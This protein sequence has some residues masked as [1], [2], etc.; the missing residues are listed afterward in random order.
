[1]LL[2]SRCIYALSVLTLGCGWAAR[3]QV[4]VPQR[5]PVAAVGVPSGVGATAVSAVGGVQ[6]R[7]VNTGVLLLLNQIAQGQMTLDEAWNK[8]LLDAPKV[9]QL[10]GQPTRLTEDQ[11][12]ETLQRDLAGLLVKL[13]PETVAKP[14]TLSARVRVALCRYYSSIGDARAVPLCEALIA[15][16][17]DGKQI[18]QPLASNPDGGSSSLWLSSVIT[19]AQF[20]QN[21][22][23]W[24]KAGET[25]ERAL[26]FWQDASWWQSSVRIEAARAYTAVDQPEKARALYAQVEQMSNTKYRGMAFYDQASFL[27]QD[28][29]AQARDLVLNAL[30]L[31][32]QPVD[33]VGPLWALAQAQWKLEEW[34][35]AEATLKEMILACPSPAPSDDATDI[36]EAAAQ[37]RLA[38]LQE[39]KTKTFVLPLT[40]LLARADESGVYH[41]TLYVHSFEPQTLQ[42]RFADTG[43]HLNALTQQRQQRTDSGVLVT[44]YDLSYSAPVA[45][46]PLQVTVSS[47]D[48]PK[49]AQEITVRADE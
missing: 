25:W 36:I 19:L 45:V 32:P 46:E 30:P 22:G 28:H 8:G 23:Q 14:E 29:P 44:A 37:R 33:R 20:Y 17:L 16:K 38:T 7:S 27:I 9:L 10:L 43:A 4:G 15:E 35:A 6:V 39:W 1:M 34:K 42:I 24:Q 18:K 12:N 3:A 41:A 48:K 5:A 47:K 2:F 49:E 11:S 26:T 21:V 13:A 40:R 31:L